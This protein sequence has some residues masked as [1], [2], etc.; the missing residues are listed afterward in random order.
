MTRD[1]FG[2]VREMALDIKRRRQDADIYRY[3]AG[4]GTG[5]STAARLSGTSQRSRVEDAVCELMEIEAD[6]E[7]REVELKP[8]MRQVRV[9]VLA[10]D[11]QLERQVMWLRY[12]ACLGWRD[13][14]GKLCVTDR[15]A[16][17]VHGYALRKLQNVT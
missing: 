15:H 14:A 1:D 8:L 2:R 16:K 7:R 12:V 9:A 13:I 10:L 4:A 3:N 6:I 11:N 5:V 17:R